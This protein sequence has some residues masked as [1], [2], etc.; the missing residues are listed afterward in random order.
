VTPT[1]GHANSDKVLVAMTV[2]FHGDDYRTSWIWG[3]VFAVLLLFLFFEVGPHFEMPKVTPLRVATIS[4]LIVFPSIGIW[5]LIL[6]IRRVDLVDGQTLQFRTNEA[7]DSIS[8][9][10]V[11][12]LVLTDWDHHH[13][14]IK[15]IAE[16]SAWKWRTTEIDADRFARAMLAINPQIPISRREVTND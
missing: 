15:V 7:V 1:A 11:T 10:D 5:F 9:T 8:V 4:I 12:R 6:P 3:W 13:Y 16:S 2:T 14:W